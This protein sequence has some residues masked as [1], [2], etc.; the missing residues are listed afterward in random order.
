VISPEGTFKYEIGS[1]TS[2]FSAELDSHLR[3]VLGMEQKED[4]SIAVPDS[5]PEERKKA[6]KQVAKAKMLIKR[7]MKK[8]AIPQ[9]EKALATDDTYAEGHLLMGEI[10]VDEGGE[11]NLAKAEKHFNRAGEIDPTN[12]KTKIGLARVQAARG[13]TEGAIA[14]L[15]KAAMIS[16]KPER[17]YYYLGQTYEKAGNLKGAVDSYRKALEK[18]LKH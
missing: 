15:S 11:E 13:D 1:Y 17:L 3:D 12:Q 7:R 2:G 8:K 9:L 5:I 14:T 4:K 16:P 18:I 10:L 6:M